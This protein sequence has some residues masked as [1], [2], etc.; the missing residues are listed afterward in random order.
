MPRGDGTGPVGRGPMT[1]RGAG[2]CAEYSVP[3]Y[4]NPGAGFC[5]GYRFSRGF[6]FGRGYGYGRGP[7]LGRGRGRGF[8]RMYN[9][10]GIPWQAR[11]GYTDYNE[12]TAPEADPK[13]FLKKEAEYLENRLLQVKERLKMLNNETE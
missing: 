8:G 9:F 1:G 6:G 12:T 4:M 3:G 5:R 13:V 11:Y 2:F 7:G 10:A